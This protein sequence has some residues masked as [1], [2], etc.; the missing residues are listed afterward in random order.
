MYVDSVFRLRSE[1]VCNP[2]FQRRSAQPSLAPFDQ[3]SQH[4][5]FGRSQPR[6]SPEEFLRYAH[7]RPHPS[8][9]PRPPL[10]DDL[11]GA[12]SFVWQCGSTVAA[13]RERRLTLFS[14]IAEALEP[15]SHRLEDMM[16]PQAT[17]IARAMALNILKRQNPSACLSDVGDSLFCLHFALF[18]AILDALRWPD[19]NL[20]RKLVL[21][22]PSVFDIP[23]SGVWVPLRRD[24]EG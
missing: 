16:S 11:E 9:Q 1:F 14:E 8:Q 15:L 7:D 24:P 21:G 4:P 12:V 6:G 13:E 10:E 17:D 22:F 3:A 2:A 20:V 18:A 23:D 5:V 19:H